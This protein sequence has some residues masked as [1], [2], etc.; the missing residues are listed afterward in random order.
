MLAPVSCPNR[1]GPGL[2]RCT[3]A[4]FVIDCTR[5]YSTTPSEGFR[6]RRVT[7]SALS[8]ENS[9]DHRQPPPEMRAVMRRLALRGPN[10][11]GEPASDQWNNALPPLGT[12]G[13]DD[14]RDGPEGDQ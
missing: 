1:A 3:Q 8:G 10:H 7:P 14:G 4:P 9:P 2:T 6:R 5:R 11:P 13:R 12:L